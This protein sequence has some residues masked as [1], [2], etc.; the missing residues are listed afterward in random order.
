[1][2]RSLS[3]A[4]IATWVLGVSTTWASETVTAE[5]DGA[6]YHF[7][8]HYSV[9]IDRP[10]ADVWKHLID[11]GSWMYEFDL[12]LE[13]GTPGQEGEVRRLYAGQDFF[14]EITKVI[15]DKLLVF[16]NLPS[17]FD[18]EHSTGVAI[19]TLEEF[20]DVTRVNLTMSRR[21]TWDKPQPNPYRSNRESAEFQ[22][23][24]R[25]MWEDR[26]LDRLRSLAEE[27]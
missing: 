18:G 5:P 10:A 4:A 12:T 26:F 24:A 8:A 19:V 27:R 17:T 22:E 1:M 16:V 7:V 21:Y 6:S 20:D 13:S 14:I 25:A 9:E 2:M 3:C 11:V 23:R 15:P